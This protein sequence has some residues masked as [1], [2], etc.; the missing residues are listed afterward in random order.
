MSSFLCRL[1]SSISKLFLYISLCVSTHLRINLFVKDH[2][3]MAPAANSK[4]VKKRSMENLRHLPLLCCGLSA[5]SRSMNNNANCMN[6]HCKVVTSCETELLLPVPNVGLDFHPFA[7]PFLH[8]MKLCLQGQAAQLPRFVGRCGRVHLVG[9]KY[10][11]VVDH[12]LASM[13]C[14]AQ[15]LSKSSILKDI[16]L[17][18]AVIVAFS[19]ESAFHS[20]CATDRFSPYEPLGEQ[21]S[22]LWLM[23][24]AVF[25]LPSS[26]ARDA[27]E[28][29]WHRHP[30]C[31]ALCGF[32]AMMIRTPLA[33]AMFTCQLDKDQRCPIAHAA[34]QHIDPVHSRPLV[35]IISRSVVGTNELFSEELC[36]CIARHSTGPPFEGCLQACV[37]PTT[38]QTEYDALNEIAY[39]ERTEHA[40]CWTRLSS[41]ARSKLRRENETEED[42]FLWATLWE[43]TRN[44]A[45]MAYRVTCRQ[46][47]ASFAILWV[48]TTV[49]F[50]CFARRLCISGNYSAWVESSSRELEKDVRTS[51]AACNLHPSVLKSK[52]SKRSA[53]KF[54]SLNSRWH[55][56]SCD[57]TSR[58]VMS[59]VNTAREDASSCFMMAQGTFTEVVSVCFVSFMLPS[60]HVN[61]QTLS[62]HAP[63]GV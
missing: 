5:G 35:A 26:C 2:T 61:T 24:R 39:A 21:H 28:L 45:E 48:H 12:A 18:A 40:R 62:Q 44:T 49:G 38:P 1:L 4:H 30:D 41:C 7:I 31:L 3:T 11:G 13:R 20:L 27:C 60:V 58:R 25:S 23:C 34:C 51:F 53:V 59:S 63:R 9:T 52:Q 14:G 57:E 29:L 56:N 16:E 54:S 6:V 17:F 10:H 8:N 36:D 46:S 19:K 33:L 37:L 55:I 47:C 50:V 43:S 42:A 15:K 22:A 32:L